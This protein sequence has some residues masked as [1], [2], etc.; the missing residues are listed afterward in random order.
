VKAEVRM[1]ND[2][3]KTA[4]L[5]DLVEP[6]KTWN[7]TRS[8]SDEVFD[9]IDLSAVDQDAKLITGAR[10][11]SCG[12]APSR[13]RQLVARGDVLVSTVRPNLNGVARVPD[14]LDGAT[15][16]TGFCVL[17]ARESKFDGGYLFQW[18]KS[19]AFVADMVNKATGASYPAVSDRI[20]FDSRI[21]L[22]PVAEQRRIAEVL[23]RAEALR[24]KRRAALAQ[25]DSLTQ[26]LFL[27]LFGDPATN[28]KGWPMK[29]LGEVATEVYRYPTYYDINYEDDGVP[30]IRGELLNSDG[31][32]V[33]DRTRLR[34][35]S[36]KTSARFPKTVLA[37]GDL[38]MS[39]RGT[40]GKIGLVP[41]ELAG[42]QITANLIR[43]ALDQT[44]LDPLFAWNVT[45]T[46]F[47]KQ[48][49]TNACSSTTIL[50]IKA[51]DLKR[52]P[53]PVPPIEL[54]REF[55]RRVTAVEAL[56]TAQRASLAELDALFASLQHRAFRGEL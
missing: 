9:Y 30:E 10:E 6:A 15:A 40:I 46:S 29:Q 56:K 31:S 35:I 39:V 1:K 36:A 2:E 20:I 14:Q 34:F 52:L 32:M 50:T 28:P 47:F 18:V 8:P 12:E 44:L 4:A 43:I 13:A 27:D 45:Q 24:A 5:G 19:P 26:S 25:L 11:V 21:P 49:I 41:P 53:V 7:P 22:P 48:Q 55:A 54:Q 51:P 23:D 37:I 42:G 17:R 3:W 33:T 16:S 38:V